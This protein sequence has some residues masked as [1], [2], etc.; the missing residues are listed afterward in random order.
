LNTEAKTIRYRYRVQE[1]CGDEWG[2]RDTPIRYHR[3]S[4]KETYTED[5]HEAFKILYAKEDAMP[6]GKFRIIQEVIEIKVILN[7]K[8]AQR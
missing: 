6:T 8:N 4:G 7:P 2:W 3:N 1:F 5:V